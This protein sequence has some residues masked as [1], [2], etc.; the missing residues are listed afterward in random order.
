MATAHLIDSFGETVRNAF[1]DF[2][3]TLYNQTNQLDAKVLS[4]LDVLLTSTMCVLFTLPCA[5]YRHIQRDCE[6]HVQSSPQYVIQQDESTRCEGHLYSKF[7]TRGELTTTGN[8]FIQHCSQGQGWYADQQGVF[9]RPA[10][11]TCAFH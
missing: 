10:E 5:D 2:L 3:G 11:G 7:A 9:M 1:N 6:E 4:V 8:G